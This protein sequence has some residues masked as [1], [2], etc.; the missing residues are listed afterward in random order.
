MIG[1]RLERDGTV[2]ARFTRDEASTLRDLAGQLIVMLTD[3]ASAGDPV[4]AVLA[5]AGIGGAETP[6]LDPALARLLP[7]AYRDD[8]EAASEHRRLTEHG[9]LQRKSDAARAVVASLS[10]GDG[11]VPVR[12]DPPAVQAWLRTLTDL[13][14]AI[15][16]R[17]GI[18]EDGD[19]GRLE[20]D[21]DAAMHAVY[22]WL[23]A[24]QGMLLEVLDG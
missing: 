8:P 4:D 16:A 15:A 23:G 2:S 6:P 11:T 3:R 20:D 1:F 14:L 10:D 12:L 7:D 19:P 21:R 17:L 9:L 13:R 22:Q 18:V 24:V 5:A